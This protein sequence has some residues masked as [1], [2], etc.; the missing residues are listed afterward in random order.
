M[1]NLY[2]SY[3]HAGFDNIPC[4]CGCHGLLYKSIIMITNNDI[5]TP[6]VCMHGV[7]SSFR[8]HAQVT[9]GL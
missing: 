3:L 8:L 2:P 6:L 5:S 9:G 7:V 1:K 4:M